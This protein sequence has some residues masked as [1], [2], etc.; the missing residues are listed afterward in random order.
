[1]RNAIGE[2]TLKEVVKIANEVHYRGEELL[3]EVGFQGD[4]LD[5]TQVQTSVTPDVTLAYIQSFNVTPS[6]NLESFKFINGG[7]GRNRTTVLKGNHTATANMSFWIP[8]DLAQSTPME[9]W[10]MKMG[11]DGTDTKVEASPDAYTVPDTSDEFGDDFLKVMT[12]EAGYNKSGAITAHK[13]TGAIVNSFTFKIEEQQKVLATFDMKAL[14]AE[15][16]TSFTAGSLVEATEHPF[17][18][19]DCEI[20]YGDASS[21]A[22]FSGVTMVEFT[23]DNAV[24]ALMD[25]ANASGNNRRY[26]SAWILSGMRTI[27]GS[28]RLNLGTATHNGQ[29]LWED[30][31]NDA[32][33]TATP[34]EGVVNKDMRITCFQDATYFLRFTLHDLN[35]GEIPEDLEG[36]GVASIT[37]PFT[38]TACILTFTT[39]NT[40]TAPT[41]WSE[42]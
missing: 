13:L 41:N 25:I 17:H 6:E 24:I 4:S 1:M 29:D 7:N 42:A 19:G 3:L 28:F 18:W 27:T 31:Y 21:V 22:A 39:L 36:Q 38:A 14:F 9:I 8:K 35:I 37:I 33:G 2:Y 34:T 23:V 12:I 16:I 15:K 11:I 10:L 26:P 30:L 32:S 20:Q 40:S 5:K